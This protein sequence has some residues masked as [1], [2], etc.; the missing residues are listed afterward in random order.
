MKT[1]VGLFIIAG[2]FGLAVDI[3]YWFVAKVEPAG[4]ALLS[5]MTIG[6]VFAAVYAYFAE[7]DAELEGDDPNVR[8]ERIA[9]EEVEIFTTHSPW[10]VLVALSSLALLAGVTWSP[11]LAGFGLAGQLYCFYRLGTESAR[12]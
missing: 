12:T 1:F 6:L 5:V 9:G 4:V 11:V 3:S 7:K 8:R 10:P 2:A